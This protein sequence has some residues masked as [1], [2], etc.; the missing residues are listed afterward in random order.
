MAQPEYVLETLVDG[1]VKEKL[2]TSKDYSGAGRAT[3]PNGD[4]YEGDFVNGLREGSQGTYTHAVPAAEDGTKPPAEVYDGPWVNNLKE[5][6]GK[7][8]Y[9]GL[10]HYNGYWLAGEKHGEGVMIYENGDIYSGNWKASKKDGKGTYVFAKT[11][12]KFIGTFRGGEIVQGKWFYPNGSCFDGKFQGNQPKGDGKWCFSNGNVVEGVY[13]QTK[14][15][16]GAGDDVKLAWK[17]T[18][19]ITAQ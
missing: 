17:T 16:D 14:K 5:G 19:D 13:T 4:V 10:G 9:P 11:G 3:Y 6:I 15:V 2:N 18:S 1:A 12:M 7:Q 8:N